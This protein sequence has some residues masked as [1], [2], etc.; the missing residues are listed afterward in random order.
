MEIRINS[1][2]VEKLLKRKPRALE[3]F[4][5]KTINDISIIEFRELRR[6]ANAIKFSGKLSNAIY[7][8]KTKK[9]ASIRV[10]PDAAEQAV[11]LE[12]GPQAFPGK[13]PLTVYLNQ[14]QDNLLLEWA[15][16]RLGKRSGKLK[17]GGKNT[18]WGKPKNK[19]MSKARAGRNRRIK[20]VINRNLT[21][22]K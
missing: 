11:L 7:R 4:M 5:S 16:S 1:S 18:S 9:R 12:E 14:S 2:K 10:R 22:I 6:Q 21:R 3:K 20:K 17:L 13:Y 15:R 8:V 19:F